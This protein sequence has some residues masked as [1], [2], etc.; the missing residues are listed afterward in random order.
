V[1]ATKLPKTRQAVKVVG[2][3]PDPE[4][5]VA[6]GRAPASG[7]CRR[8]SAVGRLQVPVVHHS[9]ASLGLSRETGARVAGEGRRH[10]RIVAPGSDDSPA[11]QGGPRGDGAPGCGPINAAGSQPAGN[12]VAA[13]STYTADV[14]PWTQRVEVLW[15]SELRFFEQRTGLLRQM[16]GEGSL[17]GFRWSEN[18]FIAQF[19]PHEALTVG[20]VGATCVVAS[21]KA[22]ADRVRSALRMT[23]EALEPRNVLVRSVSVLQFEAIEDDPGL[24]QR[25]SGAQLVHG[26][27]P[28]ATAIDWAL[29]LDGSSNKAPGQFQ[30]EFGVVS[31]GEAQQRLTRDS[32]GRLGPSG[33]PFLPDLQGF[34]R[35]S[36]FFD[37]RWTTSAVAEEA[38]YAE[39]VTVW[40]AVVQETN[41]L[42]A[43]V[44]DGY[45]S[46]DERKE[47]QA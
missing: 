23:L 32:V 33:L 9:P 1:T 5:S 19:G 12:L 29:L 11:L 7:P 42:G 18:E 17:A 24:V 41:R 2:A 31:E 40:D 8:L 28:S 4:P 21:P 27:M 47:V 36:F 15:R 6:P 44:K 38:P 34:P 20:P 16:E 35:C 25:A 22:R 10:R 37:W 43:E 14:P 13:R 30:V 3:G 26:W 45:G 39:I 46:Y